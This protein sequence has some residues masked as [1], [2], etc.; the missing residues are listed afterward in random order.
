MNTT[1]LCKQS[2][3]LARAFTLIELL[4]VILIISIICAILFPVFSKAKASAKKAS[5]ASNL[6]QSSVALDLYA[7]D[8]GDFPLGLVP[9]IGSDPG[10]R[11]RRNFSPLSPYMGNTSVLLCPMDGNG[12]RVQ[13][14]FDRKLKRSYQGMWI[15]W[16]VTSGREAWKELISQDSNPALLRCHF[17]EPRI[18]ELLQRPDL[19]GFYGMAEHGPAQGV[20]LDGSIYWDTKGHYYPLSKP[21]QSYGEDLKR[22]IW[23]QATPV[24]CPP[25]ICDGKEPEEG[26]V[27]F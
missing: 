21:L 14:V 10:G 9:A 24:D 17:H 18:A 8:H 22:T 11:L 4:T 23:S 27:E 1:N 2:N 12:G 16:E 26:I 19:N 7:G 20:R 3:R 25:K 15:L 5:C 6:H 13:Q